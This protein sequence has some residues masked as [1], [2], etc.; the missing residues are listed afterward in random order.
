SRSNTAFNSKATKTTPSSLPVTSR[1]THTNN[2]I[3]GPSKPSSPPRMQYSHQ[4]YS[5]QSRSTSSNT[6]VTNNH[7]YINNNTG[8]SPTS[9]SSYGM[10]SQASIPLGIASTTK[11][12]HS[13]NTISYPHPS[14]HPPLRLLTTATCLET[15][16]CLVSAQSPPHSPTFTAISLPK[17]VSPGSGASGSRS[18]S[19][20][21]G[22]Q[23]ALGGALG[24][25]SSPPTSAGTMK[26]SY[27]AAKESLA[28]FSIAASKRSTNSASSYS[29]N[30]NN[31]NE[32]GSN[33]CHMGG[34]IRSRSNYV[35]F[36]NFDDIDFVDVA[37]VEDKEEDDEDD[38]PDWYG[39]DSPP[40]GQRPTIMEEKM[41]RP[42]TDS[43][44]GL[45]MPTSPSRHWLLQLENFH[46]L[47]VNG[48]QV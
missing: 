16:T 28:D 39:P 36:P 7:K 40:E 12:G 20:L 14:I 1:Y 37:M 9:R 21:D 6:I 32:T 31:N 8:S 29:S 5:N 19:I 4:P 42:M 17:S 23:S 30:N 33:D 27:S 25:S 35:S 46:E 11:H 15:F 24:S 13:S 47:H 18:S 3:K 48:V 22:I 2:Q 38:H 44:I 34:V 41:M 10:S 45:G 43:R 26:N